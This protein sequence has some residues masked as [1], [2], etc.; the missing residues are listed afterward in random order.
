MEAR[1]ATVEDAEGIHSLISEFSEK[2]IL[3][4]RSIGEI[5]RDI[6]EFFVCGDDDGVAACGTLRVYGDEL[7]ELRSIAVSSER[8]GQGLGSS[9]VNACLDQARKLG[10]PAVFVLTFEAGFFARFGFE[11]VEKSELPHKIWSDCVNCPKFPD[12]DEEAMLLKL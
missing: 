3:L 10:V 1:K 8:K 9:I 7:A 4:P 5:Y 6:M 11:H 2:G 12:C